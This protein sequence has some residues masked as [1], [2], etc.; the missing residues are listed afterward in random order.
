MNIFNI[1]TIRTK[2]PKCSNDYNYN[3]TMI[4]DC[5]ACNLRLIN[6]FT[7]LN[8]VLSF[9]EDKV[10]S[11]S[12]HLKPIKETCLLKTNDMMCNVPPVSIHITEEHFDKLILLA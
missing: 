10:V 3:D 5:S 1:N 11:W 2:C 7:K 4:A 6:R 9:H 12:I 8:V